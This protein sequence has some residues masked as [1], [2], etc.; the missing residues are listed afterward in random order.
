MATGTARVEKVLLEGKGRT[1]RGARQRLGGVRELGGRHGEG[2]EA[3]MAHERL[4]LQFLDRVESE[5]HEEPVFE[6]FTASH[7]GPSRSES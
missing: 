5:R 4:D 1:L 3:A 2:I 7:Q 6:T